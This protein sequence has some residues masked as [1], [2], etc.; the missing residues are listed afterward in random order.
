MA[1]IENYLKKIKTAIY[2]KD[3]RDA[4]HDSI[5]TCYYEGKAGATDLEAR[6]RA[7]AA[8]AR[9]DAFTQL[10]KGSTTGDAELHDIRIG[11][12][13]KTYANAGTAVRE[14]LRNLHC[15][16]VTNKEPTRDNTQLW[17][18][19]DDEDTWMMPEIKDNEV[20]AVDTWSSQQIDMVNRIG[21]IQWKKGSYVDIGGNIITDAY[22]RMCSN[23]IPCYGGITVTYVAETAH[24]N[25]RAI[26][27]YDA[28]GNVLDF[29]S[30]V[31]PNGA[32]YS[33][34]APYNTRFLRLSTAE[35]IGWYLDFSETPIYKHL[36][37][38]GHFTTRFTTEVDYR[39]AYDQI[40]N[41]INQPTCYVNQNKATVNDDGSI[42]IAP[43]GYY[44]VTF[45]YGSFGGNAY[46]G[47][48]Y[49]RDERLSARFSYNGTTSLSTNEA[50]EFISEKINGCEVLKI[51]KLA[52]YEQYPYAIIRIDNRG[53]FDELIVSNIKIVDGDK[54]LPSRP[55]YVSTDGND[56]NDGTINNPLATVNQALIRGASN[57]CVMP[58]LYKQ[59]INLANS[60]HCNL[61][62]QAQEVNGSVIFTD[63]DSIISTSETLV[64]GYT[65]VYKVTTDKEFS[66]RN[67]WIFQ[68]GVPDVTT[69]IEDKER[70]PL[71]R[72]YVY[73]CEDTKIT[74]CDA[75]SLGD[76]LDEIEG[77]TEYKWFFDTDTNVIYFSRPQSITEANPLCC[78][79]AGSFLRNL[80]RNM[81]LNI[82]GIETKYLRFNVTGTV[83]SVIKDCKS[84]NVCGAGAFMYD[85]SV[86]CEFIRCEAARCFSGS[87]GDG[88]NAH[89]SNTGDIYSKQTTVT[90]TDCW[91]HDNHDDGYSDHER[92]EITIIG[93]LYEYNGK[94]GITPSYGSHCTC[95]NVYSR[96]NYAGFYYTGPVDENEGGVYGQMY[97]HG[98]VSEDNDRGGTRTGFRVDGAGNTMTLINCISLDNNNGFV[99]DTGCSARL[100]DCK[101]TGSKIVKKGTIEV[102]NPT[103]VTK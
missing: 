38:L 102:V 65:R 84:T 25:I 5:E 24:A 75:T 40:I 17:I 92:S 48:T 22:T 93:G 77:D 53:K 30:N 10:K 58:G 49:N 57:V 11:A 36:E 72:G 27:F 87:N 101:C 55:F 43:D 74:L 7:A 4:I 76:A 14:Q 86:G 32:K 95:Y 44:F 69:V 26:S 51:D 82:T 61:S 85:Q 63:T 2:G 18:N 46:V 45:T 66:D 39:I 15:I 79:T 13:G 80:S 41:G 33:V 8:E 54:P 34:T 29:Y 59:T 103:A 67:I 60:H 68:D 83:N 42:T 99:A 21:G 9:M 35:S 52:A 12:D 20:S 100:M 3:V 1:G 88:F 62:I 19:P 90:L 91:S 96:K 81:T 70:H 97:C 89:S 28:D 37:E 73:R 56:N 78:S 6:D 50:P 98:C 16:E 31:G 64:D 47:V 23:L 71:Q 94:G